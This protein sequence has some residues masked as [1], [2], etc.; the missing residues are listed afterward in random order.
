VAARAR[1]LR[2]TS[3]WP[4][5]GIDHGPVLWPVLKGGRVVDA[6]LSDRAVAEIV[7]I[8]TRR[9]GLDPKSFSRRSSRAGFLTSAAQRGASIF[10]MMDI[11]RHRTQNH[12][13]DISGIASSFAIRLVPNCF[14]SAFAHLWNRVRA[15][16]LRSRPPRRSELAIWG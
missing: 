1:S 10:K 16:G 9:I 15:E 3:G 7:K 13:L 12:W 11:S 2:S 6:R 14:R 5:Q 8:Y 4:A